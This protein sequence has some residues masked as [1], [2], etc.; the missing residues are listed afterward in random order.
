RVEALGHRR[1]GTHVL[2]ARVG[3]PA[4]HQELVV[5]VR[6]G[7]EAGRADVADRLA[8]I[9]PLPRVQAAGEPRQVTVP[10]PN[11]V[12]VSQ[13]DEVAVSGVIVLDARHDPV[14]RGADR[15]TVGCR[16]VHAPVEPLAPAQRVV[17]VVVRRVHQDGGRGERP[18][19]W[20]RDP[21]GPDKAAGDQ[22]AGDD[23]V[24]RPP[25]RRHQSI[26]RRMNV[27]ISSSFSSAGSGGLAAAVRRPG[28]S[29]GF[30]YPGGATAGRPPRSRNGSTPGARPGVSAA[31]LCRS[32]PVA[33][34][35]TR[36]SPC[37][38]GSFTV[39][40]MISASSPA[41]SL[42]TSALWVASPA[43]R[44]SPPVMLI[45]TPVAPVIEMLSSSGDE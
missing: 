39:P 13:L 11:A 10:R 40:K 20:P 25:G 4:A 27:G 22:H 44:S 6:P 33:I 23:G 31:V 38:A 17:H 42:T 19:P 43:V 12:D 16:D 30:T 35:V 29:A 26:C 3:G 18:P 1:A 7:R 21:R 45:N 24:A 14:L 32:N 5:Q 36:I 8:L 28:C 34:T 41:A 15:S 2:A 37:I 9:H